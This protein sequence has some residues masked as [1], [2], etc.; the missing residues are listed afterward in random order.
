MFKTITEHLSEVLNDPII[1]EYVTDGPWHMFT[2]GGTGG[3]ECEVGE[4]LFGL[5]KMMKPLEILETGTFQG[6]SSSYIASALKSNDMGHLDTI[7]FTEAHLN[8]AKQKWAK[9][10]ID[11]FITPHFTSSLEFKSKKQYDIL[12]LDTEPQIRFMEV[13]RYWNNLKPGGIII[14][15]DLHSEMGTSSGVWHG[16]DLIKDKI[17][18]HELSVV[19]FY[20]PRGLTLLRRANLTND[21]PDYV[22]KLLTGKGDDNK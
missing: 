20:T 18:E 1:F 10:G 17:K 4:F 9:L 14:L 19:N 11:K 16:L 12:M 15:H 6:W 22:Y 7:E 5:V 21:R 2:T 8:K 3:V 13:D